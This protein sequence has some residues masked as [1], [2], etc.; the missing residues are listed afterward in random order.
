MDL[1]V[2]R[3]AEAF[4]EEG[5]GVDVICVRGR[6]QSVR[7]EVNGVSVYRL[8]IRRKRSGK[9]HYF[10]E[11]TC[12]MTLA[13][14]VVTLLHLRKCYEVIHI[15]NMPDILVLCALIPRLTGTKVILDLHDPTP[16]MYMTKFAIPASHWMIRMM[17]MLEKWS[18]RFA[19][20]VLTPNIAFRISLFLAVVPLK[21]FI[22]S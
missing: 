9:F 3:E 20:I 8:P 1:R 14:I 7:E 6:G 12:F 4:S 10:L 15:H 5:M 2:R 18:I 16:E 21:K 13:S 11:Y 22:S 19:H 17:E